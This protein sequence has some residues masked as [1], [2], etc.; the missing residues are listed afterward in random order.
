MKCESCDQL[1]A[2]LAQAEQNFSNTVE[3]YA[4]ES[5]ERG[6]KIIELESA[7]AAAEQCQRELEADLIAMFNWDGKGQEPKRTL[8]ELRDAILAA[9]EAE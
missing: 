7:I 3:V 8:A 6:R 1:R 9:P 5:A 4:T 2:A